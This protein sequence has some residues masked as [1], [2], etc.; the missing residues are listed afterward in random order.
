MFFFGKSIDFE[1]MGT[2]DLNGG[3]L[4]SFLNHSGSVFKRL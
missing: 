3:H 4:L 2:Y 1:T